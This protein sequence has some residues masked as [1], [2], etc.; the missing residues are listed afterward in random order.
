MKICQSCHFDKLLAQ[1]TDLG[2]ATS[3]TINEFDPT[4]ACF[5]N[6]AHVKINTVIK[7]NQANKHSTIKGMNISAGDITWPK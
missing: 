7:I 5:N 4:H 6:I 2:L 1:C 3:Q